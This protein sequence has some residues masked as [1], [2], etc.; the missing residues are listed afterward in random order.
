MASTM[1]GT[2]SGVPGM[3]WKGALRNLRRNC[4]EPRDYTGYHDENR[5]LGH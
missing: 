3:A 5:A 2:Y 1:P 4:D